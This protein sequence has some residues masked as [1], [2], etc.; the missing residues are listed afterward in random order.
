MILFTHLK[1]ILLQCFQFSV[2]NNNKLNPNGPFVFF[3]LCSHH[4]HLIL[5]FF[6]FVK[7]T[8]ISKKLSLPLCSHRSKK[9]MKFSLHFTLF[10][11]KERA[12]SSLESTGSHS[13]RKI[14]APSHF[15]F[16]FFQ[17]NQ[18]LSQALYLLY[19]RV[20]P[21]GKGNHFMQE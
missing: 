20:Q 3:F 7:V 1:I 21:L 9:N 6:D 11:L 15:F 17:R 2:F 14:K 4:H 13:K 18:K 8:R 10:S 19:F 12:K 5:F 16:I